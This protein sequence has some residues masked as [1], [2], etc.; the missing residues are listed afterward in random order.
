MPQQRAAALAS[1]ASRG[2]G[3]APAI[4]AVVARPQLM[5]AL[6]TAPPRA[7]HHAIEAAKLS[8]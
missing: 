2:S 7:A 6:L 8:N 4:V 3:I 1:H 5:S